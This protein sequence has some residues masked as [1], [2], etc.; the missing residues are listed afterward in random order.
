M[1]LP[2]QDLGALGELLG[3]VAVLFTLIYLALQT[4]QNTMAIGAQLDGARLASVMTLSLAA[5]TSNEVQ[6]ALNEDQVD[7]PPISQARRAQFWFALFL[8]FQWQLHQVQHGLLPSTDEATLQRGIRLQFNNYQSFD[9]W[10][11][12]MRTQYSPDFVEWVEEQRAKATPA[13]E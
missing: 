5:A 6:E 2:I 1:T 13:A 10:W 11:E 8:N 3:S 12:G 7:A 4:R 9:G